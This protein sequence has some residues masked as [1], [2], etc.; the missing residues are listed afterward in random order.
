MEAITNQ[1]LKKPVKSMPQKTSKKAQVDQETF[2]MEVGWK[3]NENT[4]SDV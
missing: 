2:R 4:K 1:T 3:T